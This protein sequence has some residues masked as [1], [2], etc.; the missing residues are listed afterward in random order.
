MR[1]HGNPEYAHRNL[2]AGRESSRQ[3]AVAFR[4]APLR[5]PNPGTVIKKIH[6]EDCVCGRGY[7]LEIRQGRRRNAIEVWRYGRRVT[8]P[9]GNGFDALVREI[10]KDWKLRWLI[11]N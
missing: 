11:V 1:I 4:G 9:H 3:R 10:R 6:V 7:T 2:A 5:A 8:T